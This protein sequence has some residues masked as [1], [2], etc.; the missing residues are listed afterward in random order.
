MGCV[1]SRQTKPVQG[2]EAASSSQKT[3]TVIFKVLPSESEARRKF[4]GDGTLIK[5]SD[6]GHLALRTM[7]DEPLSQNC[8]GKFAAKTQV[9]DIFMCWVDIQEFKTIPTESYRRSKALHIYHKYIKDDAPLMVGVTTMQERQRFEDDIYLSKTDPSIITSS[10]YDGIQSKCFLDMYY[11]IFLPFKQTEE[12]QQLTIQ[13]KNKYN[14][15]K[16]SDF[17]YFT[18]LG[19]GGFGFVVHC[20]KKSTGKHF[21]MKIQT[22]LGLLECYKDDMI[23]VNMEKDAFASIQHPFVVNLYYAFQTPSLALMVLDLADCGDLNGCV[24]A[25]PNMRL[26]EDRVRF[27]TAEIVLALAYL[28]QRGLIY[29]DLK[30][31][32]VLLN[33]DGHVQLVDLGGVMDDQ[34]IWSEKHRPSHSPVVPL[35]SRSKKHNHQ[36][37]VELD[38]N[39]Q[40]IF[41]SEEHEKDQEEII[42]FKTKPKR[43]QSIMGTLG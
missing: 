28:H 5:N 25:A 30:P 12:F 20:K 33:A 4:E 31:Q 16:I 24:M 10:F 35:F 37:T 8:L 1:S 26:P 2:L 32:N 11:N 39:G 40:P 15:V 27:Y 17:E 42:S 3:N 22:K 34:G 7:L 36:K 13:I 23:K 21:A 29:R 38:E 43:R 6:A 18:K 41:D 9:L 19:E 14:R